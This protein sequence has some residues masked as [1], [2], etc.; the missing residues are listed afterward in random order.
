MSAE[1][2]PFPLT[3]RRAFIVKQAAHMAWQRPAA[4]E[5]YIEYQTQV[6]GDAMRR[7][8]ITERLIKRE[9]ECFQTAVRSELLRATMSMGES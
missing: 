2:L 5:R 7:R 1:V 4:A 3:R 8:G 9:L 6:Q